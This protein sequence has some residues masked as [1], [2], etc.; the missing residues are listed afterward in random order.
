MII[1]LLQNCVHIQRD[2][3]GS[4]SQTCSVSRDKK[5]VI[6]IKVGEIMCFVR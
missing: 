4:H 2:I 1:A 6:S 3:R 5:H